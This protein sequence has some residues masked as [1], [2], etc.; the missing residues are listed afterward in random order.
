[1]S[2]TIHITE[3]DIWTS[4]SV[5]FWIIVEF[6][7]QRLNSSEQEI[8]EEAYSP[9]RQGFEFIV[10]DE[11]DKD[12]F[13]VFFRN[14]SSA[15]EGFKENRSTTDFPDELFDGVV[16]CWEEFLSTLKKDD[17]FDH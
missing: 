12:T 13:G 15:F 16:N 17:R 8:L 4:G 7:W 5:A 11:L 2:G 14:C 1:M 9:L 10:L 6:T 3:K